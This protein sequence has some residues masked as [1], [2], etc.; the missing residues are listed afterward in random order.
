MRPLRDADL[1]VLAIPRP[2]RV[3]QQDVDRIRAAAPLCRIVALLGSGCEGE[4]RS[5]RPLQGVARVY[6]HQWLPPFAQG[7][8]RMSLGEACE[9]DLPATATDDER[10]LWI[11][12]KQR[13]TASGIVAVVA[14]H[15]S[16]VAA[17]AD[18]CRLAGHVVVGASGDGATQ[19]HGASVV[20][21]DCARSAGEDVARVR[22]LVARVAPTPVVVLAGFPRLDEFEAML[23]AGAAAVVSKPARLA[24]LLWHLDAATRGDAASP[25]ADYAAA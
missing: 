2:G 5:G 19:F 9:W 21:W 7:L 20:L 10:S 8:E 1:V 17:L 3:S 16:T 18:A 24:D 23:E 25:L 13:R 12:A 11:D 6:W 14:R 15:A 22:S 4:L